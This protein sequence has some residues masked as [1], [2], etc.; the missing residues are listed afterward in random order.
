MPSPTGTVKRTTGPAGASGSNRTD[1]AKKPVEIT[2]TA[3]A[4]IASRFHGPASEEALTPAASPWRK[5]GS[6]KALANSC[7][8][9][10]RSAGSFSRAFRTAASTFAGTDERSSVTDTGLPPM[11]LP[12]TAWAVLPAYGGSPTSISYRTAPSA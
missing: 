6:A 12:S 2:A 10:N 7:A 9:A 1:D 5:P 3:L 11:I 8:E 4:A